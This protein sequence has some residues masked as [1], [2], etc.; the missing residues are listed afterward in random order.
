M[1][2]TIY[3]E[4]YVQLTILRAQ[5]TKS[6]VDTEEEEAHFPNLAT[7]QMKSFH[8]GRTSLTYSAAAFC[9]V[10]QRLAKERAVGRN[11][12]EEGRGDSGNS[13]ACGDAQTGRDL[14]SHGGIRVITIAECKR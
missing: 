8:P 12:W 14:T 13:D 7:A 3:E 1:L 10:E 11:A 6:N 4:Q 2:R 9:N 5:R